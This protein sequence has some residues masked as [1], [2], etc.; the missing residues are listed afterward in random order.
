MDRNALLL[1]RPIAVG[2]ERYVERFAHDTV[3][4]GAFVPHYSEGWRGLSV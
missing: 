4:R 3:L 2:N 1:P